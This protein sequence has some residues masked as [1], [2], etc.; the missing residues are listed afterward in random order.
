MALKN[1][2]VLKGRPIARRLGFGPSPHYQVH[3]VDE[4]DDFRIAVN[5]KSKK[6]PS[7]L[8]YLIDE[9]YSHPLVDDLME[10]S[11]GFTTIERIPGGIAMDYIRGNLFRPDQMLSLPYDV[12]GPDNDLNEKIDYHVQRA[13][14]EEDAMIY[15]F[16]ERWGPEPDR[17]D[18][19]F[20][21]KPGNGIHDIHMN[22]GSVE[23]FK[24]YNGV[25]QDGGMLIHLPS[26]DRWV[27]VF[28]AFQSQCWHTDDEK[29]NC[30]GDTDQPAE[31]RSVV[32]IAAMVNPSGHDPGAERVLLL[33]TLAAAVNLD[34][35]SLADK[36]KRRHPLDGMEL[37]P[38]T[39]KALTLS[40][41]TIQLSNSG[42]IISLL[43]KEG[44]KVHGVQ[45]TKN[46]VSEQGRTIVF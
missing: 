5:V 15:A 13:L 22:Q 11:A 25:W 46:D 36:N 16:G 40:G 37:E 1:Y 23:E 43:N 32:I 3:L 44:L 2:G 17:R 7:E 29:G 39:V 26:D 12:P 45:Y 4:E 31:D 33:N 30:T 41:S 8:L 20:G 38:G 19:Y 10:L 21:F 24:K 28:L 34:G 6:S 42:G 27:A 35:W 9:N 14:A 18:K